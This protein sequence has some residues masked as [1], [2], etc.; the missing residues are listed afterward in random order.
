MNRQQRRALSQKNGVPAGK[1]SFSVSNKNAQV[2]LNF[3]QPIGWIQFSPAQ[4]VE[5]ATAILRNAV[6][7]G[8]PQDIEVLLNDRKEKNVITPT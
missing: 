6:D 5:V 1:V 4:A 8:F 2:Q 7:A 3:S